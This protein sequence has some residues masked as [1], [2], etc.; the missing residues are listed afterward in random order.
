MVA[1]ATRSPWGWNTPARVLLTVL[2]GAAALALWIEA[3]RG[4]GPAVVVPSLV[5]DPNTAP[6]AV[7]A[8]LPRL[9]PATVGR[10]VEARR[11]APFRSLEDLDRRVP[12]IGPATVE[13]LR[14]FLRFG[15]EAH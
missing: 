10:I 9:G 3:P 4:S 13:A 2:A 1:Q 6:S 14:P 15:P 7:L 11:Q 5:V 8:A 12:R